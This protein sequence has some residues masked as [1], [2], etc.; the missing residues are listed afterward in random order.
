[1]LVPVWTFQAN[2][3]LFLALVILCCSLVVH[4]HA[5]CSVFGGLLP[6]E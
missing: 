5:D 1:M 3:L 6:P 4:L 2:E